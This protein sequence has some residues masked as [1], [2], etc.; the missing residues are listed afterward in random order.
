MKHN[1]SS[2]FC[3]FMGTQDCASGRTV[4]S[5][6]V[7]NWISVFGLQVWFR[8]NSKKKDVK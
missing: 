5:Y 1:L 6:G 8:F 2:R 3:F 4:S 7:R